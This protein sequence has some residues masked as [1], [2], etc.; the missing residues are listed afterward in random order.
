VDNKLKQVIDRL[1]LEKKLTTLAELTTEALA[2]VKSVFSKEIERV[3][4]EIIKLDEKIETSVTELISV[5]DAI[6][7][8]AVKTNETIQD[9]KAEVAS[10]DSD[11]QATKRD[12]SDKIAKVKAIKGDRGER[13]EKGDRGERGLR[14]ERGV[15]GADGRD[16]I[17]GVT[18]TIETKVP[19]TRDDVVKLAGDLTELPRELKMTTKAIRDY[20]EETIRIA[21]EVIPAGGTTIHNELS[22]RDAAATHPASSIQYGDGNVGEILDNR[23]I[24]VDGQTGAVDLS[25]TYQPKEDQRLSTTDE[26]AFTSV[27]LVN[28]NAEPVGKLWWNEVDGTVDI[29]LKNGATLQTGQELHFYGKASGN[30]SNGD[31]LQ[32]AGVQG[33]HI[34]MKKAV[35][36]EIATHPEYLVGIATQNITNGEFG[37]VT[38]FGKVN[39]VFT[40]GFTAGDILYFNTDTSTLQNTQPDAPLRRII[41]ASVIKEATGGAENGT[42]LVRPTWGF[43][44]ADLDDV[45]GTD[46]VA[47]D[48]PQYQ[49]D[50]TWSRT[51]LTD[52]NFNS[53]TAIAMGMENGTTLPSSPAEGQWFLLK[54]TNKT[55][56]YE[57]IKGIWYA[58]RSF[59]TM[60]LYVDPVL[61][62]DSSEKGFGTG[63]DAYK[64]MQYAYNQIPPIV[65]SIVT[66]N[67]ADGTYT[68]TSTWALTPRL[69]LTAGAYV[70]IRGSTTFPTVDS[71]TATSVTNGSVSAGATI[72]DTTKTWV[73]DSLEGK[74]ITINGVNYLIDS[75]TANTITI[76]GYF[77]VTP[78]NLAYTISTQGAI[79]KR[80]SAVN[81]YSLQ[82]GMSFLR[83]ENIK[84][85]MPLTGNIGSGN[86][87]THN[88]IWCWFD[89]QQT[90]G[91]ALLTTITQIILSLTNCYAKKSVAVSSNPFFAI[92]GLSS[93]SITN[94]LLVGAPSTTVSGALQL[95]GGTSLISVASIYKNWV[96]RAV[97]LQTSYWAAGA[98]SSF[99]NQF[100][101]NG[102]G[103]ELLTGSVIQ[104]DTATMY[105]GN[106]YDKFHNWSY[107]NTALTAVQ[108][109]PTLTISQLAG[110]TANLIEMK[111]SVGTLTN[112][113]DID[114]DLHTD[115]V[116]SLNGSLSLVTSEV[117]VGKQ[118][119]GTQ[120]DISVVDTIGSNIDGGD[121]VITGQKSTGTGSGGDI[122]FEVG[123]I[124]AGGSD[125]ITLGNQQSLIKS[126]ASSYTQAHTIA[127]NPDRIMFVQL[128]YVATVP[129]AT[130]V[131]YNGVAMT[132]LASQV[133]GT[134]VQQL[135]YLKNPDVGT[136]NVVVTNNTVAAARIGIVDY[137]NVAQ[138]NTFGS[139][140]SNAVNSTTGMSATLVPET[141]NQLSIAFYTNAGGGVVV[142]PSDT[143]VYLLGSTATPVGVIAHNY[144]L[145][146]IDLSFTYTD[147]SLRRQAIYGVVLRPSSENINDGSEVLRITKDG[148][149]TL[150]FSQSVVV[151]SADC[152]L[153]KNDDIVIFDTSATAT[154]PLATGSGKIYKIKSESGSGANVI[155]T[156]SGTDTID[157]DISTMVT[158]GNSPTLVDYAGGKWA[159]I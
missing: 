41:V 135:W 92:S 74:R 120:N 57:Y 133:S 87:A 79:I 5:T 100:K 83:F 75:N 159:L 1:E 107:G 131:T 12:L 19:L 140:Y 104:I 10:V 95:Q 96:G 42:F 68:F 52:V 16:G 138:N 14:G 18:T 109:N 51:I 20:R 81:F 21:S 46:P 113:T 31:V 8:D 115:K 63:A 142:T 122:V 60:T 11:L 33:D 118:T 123:G 36:A 117:K 9:V 156:A 44:F 38:W 108:N 158:D 65:D 45:D 127:N 103:L 141:P 34:L 106:T 132:E 73:V 129:R 35:G 155:V 128:Y 53:Q 70:T 71:G 7:S 91:S 47:G 15:A 102:I 4:G 130:A 134:S 124:G 77:T 26:V 55:I 62:T 112:Y 3:D 24:S 101:N 145:N 148:I 27:T 89:L 110:Q 6:T 76:L 82:T 154:L 28:P 78:T 152:T 139:S 30:I 80:S 64:T 85:E 32:F 90:N 97:S 22:G 39:G 56:L 69:V 99:M 153:D 98:V 147:G 54:A 111:N 58:T 66:I 94:S 114:G 29:S 25:D 119:N 48:I 17:D 59:G 84:F 88:F 137:Y 49:S 125:S 143:Q 151:K 144:E 116:E 2:K 50:G 149:K 93:V 121:L 126:I 157:G 72:T 105:S 37:Y 13:G 67:L 40:T 61:G 150:G 86:G 136:F 23:V 43:R 146:G